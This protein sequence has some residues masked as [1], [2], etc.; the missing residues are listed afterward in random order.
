MQDI[1]AIES[2]NIIDIVASI[3]EGKVTAVLDTHFSWHQEN[4]KEAVQSVNLSKEK[5]TVFLM[6]YY[7][8]SC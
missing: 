5:G 6:K 8:G 1:Y 7:D 4:V 3:I 2:Y